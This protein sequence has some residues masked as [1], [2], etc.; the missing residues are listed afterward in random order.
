[1]P[2]SNHALLHTLLCPI[3]SPSICMTNSIR[4]V[5]PTISDDGDRVEIPYAAWAEIERV[6]EEE[7]NAE[8]SFHLHEEPGAYHGFPYVPYA[9][10]SVEVELEEELVDAFR[11]R[12]N[13][14]MNDLIESH[15]QQLAVPA[16]M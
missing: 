6:A 15:T 7:F 1:M 2:H 12:I 3:P 10:Y 14:L 11:D 8:I 5:I 4:R 13:P 16:G 9:H